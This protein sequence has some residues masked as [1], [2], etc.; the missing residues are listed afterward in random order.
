MAGSSDVPVI[1]S[2]F[3]SMFPICSYY[4][5]WFSTSFSSKEQ[6]EEDEDKEYEDEEE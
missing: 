1:W 3:S 5:S 6:D 2:G 4:H